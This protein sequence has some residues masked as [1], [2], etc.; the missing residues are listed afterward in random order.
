MGHRKTGGDDERLPLSGG[1]DEFGAETLGRRDRAEGLTPALPPRP[2]NAPWVAEPEVA[3]I[4]LP[5]L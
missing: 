2:P 1:P 4:S 3:A 5:P